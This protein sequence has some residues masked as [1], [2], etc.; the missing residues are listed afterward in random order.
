MSF[1][2]MCCTW[3]SFVDELLESA[4]LDDPKENDL[5][6]L[7]NVPT[8]R[9]RTNYAWNLLRNLL[10]GLVMGK[11]RVKYTKKFNFSIYIIQICR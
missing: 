5:W 1:G 10:C 2:F 9:T 11:L 7:L 6:K 8:T 3:A 4:N